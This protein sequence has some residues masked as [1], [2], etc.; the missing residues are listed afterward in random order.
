M[1]KQ[2]YNN[3][4]KLIQIKNIIID[5]NIFI[6]IMI[7]I[8]IIIIIIIIIITTITIKKWRQFL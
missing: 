3:L 8:V 7:M 5:H 1:T 6:M 4:M 2:V